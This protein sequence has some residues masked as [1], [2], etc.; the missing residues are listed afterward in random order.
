MAGVIERSEAN[1]GWPAAQ[2]QGGRCESRVDDDGHATNA[3]EIC[4]RENLGDN[5][6]E[7]YVRVGG[8]EEKNYSTDSNGV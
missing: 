6:E 1:G 3:I 8:E 5:T 2:E 4:A 7:R